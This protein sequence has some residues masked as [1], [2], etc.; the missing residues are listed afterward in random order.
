MPILRSLSRLIVLTLLSG[1][2]IVGQT[3]VLVRERRDNLCELLDQLSCGGKSSRLSQSRRDFASPSG[4]PRRPQD[5]Q[6]N[7]SGRLRSGR[8]GVARPLRKESDH[9]ESAV[10]FSLEHHRSV[11]AV[12]PAGDEQNP[13]FE[14]V[15]P[16]RPVVFANP[17]AVPCERPEGYK[18]FPGRTGNCSKWSGIGDQPAGRKPNDLVFQIG[19]RATT[20]EKRTGWSSV[21]R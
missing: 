13:D 19:T 7:C 17:S 21:C 3:R 16:G 6:I 1:S 20:N 2:V 11:S 9:G 15:I 14:L 4:S 5:R 10:T 12:H 18:P 8:N